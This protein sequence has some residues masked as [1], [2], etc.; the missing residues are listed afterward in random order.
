MDWHLQKWPLCKHVQTALQ[1]SPQS[2]FT[3]S[4]KPLCKK[5]SSDHSWSPMITQDHDRLVFGYSCK[6]AL[7]KHDH[8]PKSL[9]IGP[10]ISWKWSL[11]T[12][13]QYS[14]IFCLQI[15]IDN[16]WSPSMFQTGFCVY[17]VSIL[18]LGLTASKYLYY[19]TLFG[20]VQK[21]QPE[22]RGNSDG[23]EIVLF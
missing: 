6:S 23:D 14:W 22:C 10:W 5:P 8:H 20:G 12:P 2:V 3:N 17:G 18:W 15:T 13:K 1:I 11:I 7:I 16:Q 21:G 9:L 4:P 19:M